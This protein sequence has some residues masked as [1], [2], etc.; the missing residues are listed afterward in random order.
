[1]SDAQG[2]TGQDRTI[3]C[4]DCHQSFAFTAAE[5]QF[6]SAKGFRDRPR[7]CAPCR[8]ARKQRRIEHP[9]AAQRPLPYVAP[10]AA[11]AERTHAPRP[12][13][14]FEATC[15]VCGDMTRVHFSPSTG[16]PAFCAACYAARQRQGSGLAVNSESVQER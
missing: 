4:Q 16:R 6:F 9:R 11:D 13:V 2:Q 15:F 14:Q 3:E 7:R 8:T 1:M 12:R 5:E 10:H